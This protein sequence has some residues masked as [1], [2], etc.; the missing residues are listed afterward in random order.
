MRDNNKVC[1]TN[2]LNDFLTRRF[3]RM[4]IILSS[5]NK[6][7]SFTNFLVNC[8]YI[9]TYIVINKVIVSEIY[10]RL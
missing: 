4:I 5:Q 8:D 9:K 6:R 1:L 10:E 2:T 7:M 3:F